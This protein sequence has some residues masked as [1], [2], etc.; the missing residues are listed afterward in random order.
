VREVDI[1]SRN[2]PYLGNSAMFPPLAPP[3]TVGY[4]Q[5]T[6]VM[7]PATTE[8]IYPPT[9][10]VVYPRVP[11]MAYQLGSPLER[12]AMG[13]ITYGRPPYYPAYR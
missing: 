8:I 4:S 6:E 11:P 3:T 13:S 2:P 12:Q 1:R 7:Y 5:C 9:T 10:E